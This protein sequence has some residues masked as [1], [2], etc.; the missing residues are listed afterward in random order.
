MP[1]ESDDAIED[2]NELLMEKPLTLTKNELLYLSDSMTLLMEHMSEQGRVHIP[3][4]QLLPS[5]SVPVPIELIQN[6]GLGLLISTDPKN[7]SQEA[8][9][10]FSVADLYLLRECCQSFVKINNEMVGYNLLRKIYTLIL[11]ES[12]E[13]REFIN[14]LTTGIDFS[15]QNID[16]DRL[17]Y[18]EELRQRHDTDNTV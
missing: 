16:K 5:A 8:T 7:V 4:R 13:E 2:H 12:M 6:I 18:L 1:Y 15:M 3:A 11:E 14:K 10:T 17:Q 9:I